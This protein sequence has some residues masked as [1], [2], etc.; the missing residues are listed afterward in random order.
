M[1]AHIIVLANEKGGTGKSTL[2]MHILVALL[3]AKKNVVSFDLDAQRVISVNHWTDR[4][5]KDNM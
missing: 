3:R 2:A 1:T 4:F 5:Y